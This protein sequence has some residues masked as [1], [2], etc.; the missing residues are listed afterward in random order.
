MEFSL[1]RLASF[2]P[3][4]SVPHK[5]IQKDLVNSEKHT[6]TSKCLTIEQQVAQVRDTQCPAAQCRNSA[7]AFVLQTAV[8]D[9]WGAV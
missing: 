7:G 5:E 1:P 2:G 8:V 9:W 3:K 6:L 4:D